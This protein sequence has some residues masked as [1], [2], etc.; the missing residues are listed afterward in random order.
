MRSEGIREQWKSDPA[1]LDAE[2]EL[3]PFLDLA[4]DMLRLRLALGLSQ[5][6]L[7][8]RMGTRQAN[9]SRV[10]AGLSNPTLQFLQRL[11]AA[12]DADLVVQLHPRSRSS[13]TYQTRLTNEVLAE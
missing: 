1:F 10:E 2:R 6:E 8:E 13:I 11:A 3:K 4:A 12:L 5:E 9:I 7:A